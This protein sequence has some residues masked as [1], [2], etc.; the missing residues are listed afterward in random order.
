MRLRDFMAVMGVRPA[1]VARET[2]VHVSTIT[3]L[4]TGEY[5]HPPVTTTLRIDR[6]AARFAES[7]GLPDD[8]ELV[9]WDHLIPTSASPDSRGKTSRAGRASS[10][11]SRAS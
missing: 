5:K 7:R 1:E 10:S 11:E 3:R 9:T 4:N 6:W 2:G 8:V